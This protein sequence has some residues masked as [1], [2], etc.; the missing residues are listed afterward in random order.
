MLSQVKINMNVF[1]TYVQML[2]NVFHISIELVTLSII[3]TI[4]IS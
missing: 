3:A 2:M 1:P 4:E